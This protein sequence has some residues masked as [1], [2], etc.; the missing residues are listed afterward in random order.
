MTA[1]ALGVRLSRAELP[2]W[3]QIASRL[4]SGSYAAH[5]R[6]RSSARRQSASSAAR[7]SAPIRGS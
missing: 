4:R 2:P 3:R 5:P 1:P 6:A 7:S